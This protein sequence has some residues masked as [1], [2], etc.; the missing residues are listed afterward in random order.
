MAQAI[1]P[2]MSEGRRQ[3]LER[4]RAQALKGR[5]IPSARPAGAQ[6]V[7]RP[8]AAA[9]GGQPQ[10]Q[11]AI[12]APPQK[13]QQVQRSTPAA[14][15]TG[16]AASVA[17]RQAMTSR[18][19]VG[20]AMR[21][22]AER[23]RA[24]TARAR[25][26]ERK[27]DKDDCGCG[28]RK[29]AKEVGGVGVPAN[30]GGMSSSI[31]RPASKVKAATPRRNI[32]QPEGRQL[33]QARRRM[34]AEKG[35]TALSQT[36]RARSPAER[37]R[38]LNPDLNGRELAREVRSERSRSGDRGRK[39]SAPSGRQRPAA[40]GAEDAPWKVGSSQTA[41]GQ[42]ATGTQV[43]RGQRR[44]GDE[45]SSCRGITGTE[46]LA[47]DIFR[48]FCQTDLVPNPSKA[49][50]TKT[51]AGLPVTGTEVG[52]STKVT[53]NEAGNCKRV[54]GNEYLPAGQV[55]EFCGTAPQPAPAKVTTT[56]T[57]S[58]R[59][60]SGSNID[61]PSR[62]SGMEAGAGRATTGTSY[63]SPQRPSGAKASPLKV[64]VTSTL[65]GGQVTGTLLGRNERVT[66]NEPGSCRQVTGDEYI[67]EEQ[68]QAFCGTAPRPEA[69]KF[70]VSE[71]IKGKVV[72]GT[73][74]GRGER[75]TGDEP[76]TS[77]TVTP[78]ACTE[79]YREYCAP[80][81]GDTA[82][83]HNRAGR[84]MP[85]MPLVGLQQGIGGKMTGERKGANEA[86]TGPSYGQDQFAQSGG[87][88]GAVP[89]NPDFPQSLD[90]TPWAAT[91][92]VSTPAREAQR[93]RRLS[94]VT[95]TRY[96]QG[97]I[98]GPFVM[99]EGKITGTEDFRFGGPERAAPIAPSAAPVA[100]GEG[101]IAP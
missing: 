79:I 19:K 31:A 14:S 98:T 42:T 96:E 17:R 74:A 26:I 94:G 97:H 15:S 70:G 54:T 63:T 92:S 16:R 71:T 60:V 32:G 53:G 66:G 59:Q 77:K 73:Q 41:Q 13:S 29:E 82:P 22:D 64:G 81:A 88:L 95:G 39:S 91:F 85:G 2:S 69:P 25:P 28:G 72:T 83:A 78:Y 11:A 51:A 57:G 27:A 86:I 65:R 12:S 100:A 90:G 37:A 84:T 5:A 93:A 18:G 49:S 68:Y 3:A 75:V 44:T 33:A 43:G 76:G 40:G 87:G 45:L 48:E 80:G 10:A 35:R 38:H 30:N 23:T 6:S 89:G 8:S 52:R 99:G 21:S 55:S 62:M 58:G 46:Y 47:A 34:L 36:D 101:P 61:R 67:G 4:R 50:L 56:R 24:E 20:I 9:A 7:A 1:T